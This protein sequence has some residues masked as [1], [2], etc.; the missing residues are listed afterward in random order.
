[1]S[2]VLFLGSKEADEQNAQFLRIIWKAELRAVVSIQGNVKVDQHNGVLV[3]RTCIKSYRESILN[4]LVS[5]FIR[6][7]Y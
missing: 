7:I 3:E 6:Y 2:S 5:G 1:M 4:G